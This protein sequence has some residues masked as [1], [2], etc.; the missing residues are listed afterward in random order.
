M[1]KAVVALGCFAV[2]CLCPFADTTSLKAATSDGAIVVATVA[3]SKLRPVDGLAAADFAVVSNGVDAPVLTVRKSSQPLAIVIVADGLSRIDTL[4][5]RAAMR[6]IVN[7]ARL[8]AGGARIGVMSGPAA[9]RPD[10]ADPDAAERR[11][12]GFLR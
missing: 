7:A 4:R 9:K 8:Y 1:L 12:G 5:S 3:D 11:V 10:L 2:L 6:E